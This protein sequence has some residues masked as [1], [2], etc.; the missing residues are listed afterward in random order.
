[1]TD[2]M[3]DVMDTVRLSAIFSNIAATRLEDLVQRTK[4]IFQG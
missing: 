4:K 3:S 2:M 1:M